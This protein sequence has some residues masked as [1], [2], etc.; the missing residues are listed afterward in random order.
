MPGPRK[1]S[2]T[3]RPV[4]LAR[5]LSILDH[6]AIPSVDTS[7]SLKKMVVRWLKWNLFRL[8]TLNLILKWERKR[9]SSIEWRPLLLLW[10]LNCNNGRICK[11]TARTQRSSLRLVNQKEVSCKLKSML[12]VSRYKKIWKCTPLEKLSLLRTFL[13]FM[14]KFSK[15]KPKD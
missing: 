12:Q 7:L 3:K 1:E 10:T 13:I 8:R 5:L 11:L 9:L 2:S 14:P 6:I 4:H 15:K